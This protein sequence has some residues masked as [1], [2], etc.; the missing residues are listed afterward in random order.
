M[1]KK[2]SLTQGKFALVDAEDYEWLNQWKWYAKHSYKN[3]FYACRIDKKREDN[4]RP[5][6]KMHRC[7]LKAK[8]EEKSDHINGDGL[9]NRRCNLRIVTTRQNNQNFYNIQTSAYAG[10]SK[11]KYL[12]SK[13][14]RAGIE[15]NNKHKHLGYFKTEKEA[16]EAYKKAV[17]ELTGEKVVCEI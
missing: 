2:I 3:I 7:I 10:V 9:D 17:H 12:K 6:Y 1:V 4:S 14:W 8:K 11:K 15:I 5:I 16:F 13:P